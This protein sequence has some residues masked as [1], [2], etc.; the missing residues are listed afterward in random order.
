MWT[1]GLKKEIGCGPW[2]CIGGGVGPGGIWVK[3]FF[4]WPESS[5]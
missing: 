5:E 3:V 1:C 2:R 4:P